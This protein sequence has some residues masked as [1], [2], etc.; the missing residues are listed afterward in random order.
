MWF[1]GETV[2]N[3]AEEG[4]SSRSLHGDGAKKKNNEQK[5]NTQHLQTI[6]FNA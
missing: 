4:P 6:I 1:T 5:S 3:K 2:V